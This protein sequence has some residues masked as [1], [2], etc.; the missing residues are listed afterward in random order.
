[1]KPSV[2]RPTKAIID[3]KAIR[4]NVAAFKAYAN[5]DF[6]LFAVV[7]ANAYGHGVAEVAPAIRDIVD[8]YAVSNLD[9]AI[10]LRS[11]L[12]VQ[13]ILVLSGIIPEDIK[14][15]SDLNISLT[16]PSLEWLQAILAQGVNVKGLRL[17]LKIDS[18]MGRIGVRDVEEANAIIRLIQEHDM[19]FEGVFT[20]FA[21]ADEADRH[22]FDDQL[23][24]FN[25]ILAGLNAQPTY[26]HSSNTASGM[27][28]SDT[29]QDIERLGIGLYG[30]NPSGA[31]LE[32]PY[33]LKPALS[34][35]SALSHVKTISKGESVGYG[36]E[37]IAG[38]ETVIGTLPIGYADGW[39]RDMKGF[40]VLVD[41]QLC[42]IVGRISMDQ[43]TI[44]LP[45]VYPMGT[46]VTLIGRDGDLEITMEDVA[47]YRG[48]INYEVA[49]LLSD[50]IYREYI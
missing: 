34:L 37:Y 45:K 12:I 33:G 6:Q 22:K 1:M 18:G 38:D 19:V 8:G 2:H 3:L 13:P 15:A 44:A 48:T 17:H 32:V 25:T 28:H 41:G 20:H 5:K 14:I 9:E 47:E 42:P 4:D 16:I 46:P 43:T 39:T 27:W 10:E 49:C 21:T 23:E 40:H 30:L 36:A 26:I 24:R 11:N 29:I 7:K 31:A 35:V 50:R